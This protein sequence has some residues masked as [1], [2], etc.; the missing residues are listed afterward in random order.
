M[1]LVGSVKYMWP[2]K[3]AMLRG[4]DPASASPKTGGR[5]EGR[6]G[7]G[8]RKD[9]KREGGGGRGG[10]R[11]GGRKNGGRKGRRKGGGEGVRGRER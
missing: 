9:G 10:G 1:F 5:R 7:G 2:W 3:K 11:D 6:E 4:V 8:G